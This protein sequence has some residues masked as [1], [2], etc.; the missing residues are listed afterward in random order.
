MSPV[1]NRTSYLRRGVV[2]VALTAGLTLSAVACSSADDSDARGGA[3]T[4][5]THQLGETKIEGTPKRVV[6]LGNQWLDAT[7]ALGVTPVGY[8]DNIAAINGGKEPAWEPASLKDSKALSASGDI[9]EEVAALNPDLILAPGFMLDKATYDKLSK[10]APTIGGLT[11]SQID[12]W[13]DQ[14]STLGKVLHKQD[15]ATKVTADVDAKI[16]A[17]AKKYPGLKGKTFLTTWLTGPTQLMVMADKNDGASEMF[18]AL[19]MVVPPAIEQEAAKSHGR[20]ALSPERLSDLTSDLIIAAGDPNG[21]K[22]LPGYNELPAV[23]KN[24]VAFVDTAEIGGVNQPTPLSV[25][26]LLDKLDPAFAAAAK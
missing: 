17:T 4:T 26:Y 1:R 3:V 24:S 25:P 18:T 13:R 5:V 16:A 21:Y 12:P 2:S 8:I 19:G 6:A 10:L 9:A 23:Q 15:E 14:V 7:E 22:A 11:K 20:M